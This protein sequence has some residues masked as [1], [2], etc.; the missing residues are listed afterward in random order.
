[1]T[2]SAFGLGFGA[3]ATGVVSPLWNYSTELRASRTAEQSQLLD[4]VEKQWAQ[5]NSDTPDIVEPATPELQATQ[6]VAQVAQTPLKAQ[7]TVAKVAEVE[8]P[9]W[10]M[11]SEVSPA[12]YGKATTTL[13]KLFP[14]DSAMAKLLNVGSKLN[15]E[16][17]TDAIPT[18]N[19]L[20]S[21][22][23]HIASAFPDGKV[24][25]AVA[26][27]R[28]RVWRLTKKTYT[29]KNA[30][31]DILRG[32]TADVLGEMNRYVKVLRN[33]RELWE[34]YDPVP[35][36]AGEFTRMQADFL[37]RTGRSL[38]DDIGDL[39][40]E[41]PKELSYIKD[42]VEL[43]QMAAKRNDIQFTELV[44]ELN[45]MVTA[46]ME[47]RELGDFRRY[48]DSNQAYGKT[49]KMTPPEISAQLKKEGLQPRTAEY[50]KRLTELKTYGRTAV[51][52]EVN[53]LGNY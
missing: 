12:G 15:R 39:A 52:E 34:G 41:L 9:E 18:V 26:R 47:Q 45:G 19:K 24:P 11:V 28:S 25:K 46:R 49:V 43:N 27:E 4:H 3:I 23:L 40:K 2:D 30:L 5:E 29:K 44:E 20:N 32:D 7:Q 33:H 8:F 48:T 53:Q 37:T 35:V 22:I 17:A 1:M 42:V 31:Q 38:D 50:S 51:P 36:N 16:A 6:K 21:D 13:R 10:S 14:E